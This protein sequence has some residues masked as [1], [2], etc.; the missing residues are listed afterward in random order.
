M[1][2][3]MDA[4]NVDQHQQLLLLSPRKFNQ[5]ACKLWDLLIVMHHLLQSQSASNLSDPLHQGQSHL[6]RSHKARLS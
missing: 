1:I 5:Q 3:T 4:K 6:P 2:S